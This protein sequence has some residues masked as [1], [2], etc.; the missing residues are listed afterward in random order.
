MMIEISGTFYILLAQTGCPMH[1]QGLLG[2]Y[3]DIIR[4]K[5]KL[6]IRD[7]IVKLDFRYK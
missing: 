2:H 5:V 6:Q 3:M 4:N 1:F 7:N